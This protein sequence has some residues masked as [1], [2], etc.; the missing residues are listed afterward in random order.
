MKYILCITLL[1]ITIIGCKFYDRDPLSSY[2]TT[3]NNP[4]LAYLYNSKEKPG[5]YP[6]SILKDYKLGVIRGTC[7]HVG[8]GKYITTN[9]SLIKDFSNLKLAIPGNE[10]VELRS[11]YK[12]NQ[13]S[14]KFL[15]I[16]SD[17]PD[18]K[19]E[20]AKGIA[21]GEE[22]YV[23]TP[24]HKIPGK[25]SRFSKTA[26]KSNF[27][28]AYFSTD[29]G[30]KLELLGAPVVNDKLELIGTLGNSRIHTKSSIG[31]LGGFITH[32]KDSSNTL[33]KT[34]LLT[35]IQTN[36]LNIWPN[37]KN[38]GATKHSISRS[39]GYIYIGLNL[40]EGE[41]SIDTFKQHLQENNTGSG[42]CVHVGEGK[43][44]T[45]RHV[46]DNLLVNQ[47]P[48]KLRL[49]YINEN[50]VSV[51]KIK[52][53]DTGYSQ[54]ADIAF[55]YSSEINDKL[56]FAKSFSFDSPVYI[57]TPDKKTKYDIT[58]VSINNDFLEVELKFSKTKK[59]PHGDSGSPVL[60]AQGE[61]IGIFGQWTQCS[62][63]T[64]LVMHATIHDN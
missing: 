33:I 18:S 49:V 57:Q 60:N 5:I 24:E 44:A 21:V 11:I 41:Y 43:Y 45:A 3:E 39:V 17:K 7:I 58:G 10:I 61:I 62:E 4:G 14:K 36:Q 35:G 6:L 25:L 37:F 9:S 31:T 38:E 64:S 12:V 28:N 2:A 52:E 51:K 26:G 54:S 46:V 19:Y 47:N 22:V 63:R 53:I 48:L 55:V 23:L 32:T 50:K 56:V 20:A 29:V 16:T 8:E 59:V 15:E 13:E 42:V 1:L 27:S 30:H 40:D 34:N